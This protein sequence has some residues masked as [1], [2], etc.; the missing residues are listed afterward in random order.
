MYTL[1]LSVLLHRALETRLGALQDR[2]AVDHWQDDPEGLHQVRIASRRVRAVLDLVDRELYPSYDR[3][4]RKLRRLTRALGGPRE[5]DVHA[6]LLDRFGPRLGKDSTAAA[7]EHVQE[8]FGA[9]QRK[10]RAGMAKALDRMSLKHL[11]QLLEVPSLANPFAAGELG[12]GAWECLAPW[13]ERAFLPLPALVGEE[14]ALALHSARI[15]VKKLRYTLEILAPAFAAEPSG[16]LR[17]LK[18]FQT[19]LG[20]HH[21]LATL[22]TRLEE[23]LAGLQDRNRTALAAGVRAL[24]ALV[25]EERQCAYEQFR[26]LALATSLEAF[27]TSL[28]R[29]LMAIEGG[30]S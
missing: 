10:A 28:K 8:Q 26:V 29:L 3:Q 7:L 12:T 15:D 22:A 19:A 23:V 17:L 5:L 14:D 2:L 1:E 4:A 16:P 27:Q 21:D 18:A 20:D 6:M 24:L 13:L 25:A 11:D 9:A 30:E